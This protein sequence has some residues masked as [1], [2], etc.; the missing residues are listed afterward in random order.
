MK[1]AKEVVAK[2]EAFALGLFQKDKALSIPGANSKVKEK[3]GSMIR[4]QRLYELRKIAQAGS[5]DNAAPGAVLS[6]SRPAEG[7]TPDIS[8]AL[9]NGMTV[10]SLDR[11]DQGP[12]LT[13]VMGQLRNSNMGKLDVVHSTESYAIIAEKK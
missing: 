7:I 9:P 8:T 12:F 3:F 2:R 11:P 10:I 13:K 5:N 1:L 6:A 4:A